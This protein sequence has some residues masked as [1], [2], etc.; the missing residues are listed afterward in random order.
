MK[1]KKKRNRVRIV[2]PNSINYTFTND[3]ANLP[4]KMINR[5]KITR[6]KKKPVNLLKKH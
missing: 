4:K 2:K 6:K 1:E 5:I 3:I